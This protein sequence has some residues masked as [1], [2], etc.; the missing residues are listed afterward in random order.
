MSIKRK[1]RDP[2]LGA[3]RPNLAAIRILHISLNV[4]RAECFGCVFKLGFVLERRMRPRLEIFVKTEE[5]EAENWEIYGGPDELVSSVQFTEIGDTQPV[6]FEGMQLR[7]TFTGVE[8][9]EYHYARTGRTMVP[10]YSFNVVRVL[11]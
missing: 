10:A 9:Q 8:D 11:Q 1:R 2:N 3:I 7:I 4:D 6:E 5:S